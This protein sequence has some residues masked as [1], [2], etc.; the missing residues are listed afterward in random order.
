MFSF[1]NNNNQKTDNTA[2]NQSD[3][4]ISVNGYVPA[5]SGTNDPLSTQPQTIQPQISQQTAPIT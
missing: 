2:A 3:N 4:N 1:N 5:Y